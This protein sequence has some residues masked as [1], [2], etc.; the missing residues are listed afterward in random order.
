MTEVYVSPLPST[1]AEKLQIAEVTSIDK[2]VGSEKYW[3]LPID[4]LK[5][6]RGLVVIHVCDEN[7]DITRDFC[8]RR[9]TLVSH[10]KYFEHFLVETEGG[11]ED[12]DISVHCDI[13]IFEWLM[14]Y[15]HNPQSPPQ[16]DKTIV[17]S[18]LISSD[19]LQIESLVELCLS[20]VA[21]NLADIIKLPIDLSC[22][23]EKLLTRLAQLTP[24]QVCLFDLLCGFSSSQPYV[25]IHCD[26]SFWPTQRTGR[27]KY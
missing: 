15:I 9:D 1:L 11:Y 3:R 7:R 5:H 23:S 26:G 10:M 19:F 25:C 20:F 16:M 14:A 21:S 22:I 4:E 27:I 6:I 8:C 17:I 12:I 13:D 18:I 2:S 24:A